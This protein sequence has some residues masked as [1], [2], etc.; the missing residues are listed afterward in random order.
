MRTLYL[1]RH[2]KAESGELRGADYDRALAARGRRDAERMGAH[3]AARPAPPT[4]FLCSSALRA[5]Q[6]LD[7]VLERLPLGER[8]AFHRDLYLA[9]PERIL[10]RVLEV[11]DAH[12]AVLVVGHNPGIA[13]L[14]ETLAQ[15]PADDP[16]ALLLPKFPTAALAVLR[17]DVGRWFDLAPS[18]AALEFTSPKLLAA[19]R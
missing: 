17:F 11:D 1:L 13:Q 14:A 4:F 5:T 7:G 3:L 6:T 2:G 16:H 10:E 9:G 12:P 18:R 8:G 19:T 15:P